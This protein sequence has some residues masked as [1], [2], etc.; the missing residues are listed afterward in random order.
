MKLAYALK[1]IVRK[2]VH[3]FQAHKVEVHTSST[4]GEILKGR[5]AT[6]KIAKWVIKLS[7]YDIEYKPR[8]TIKAQAL[9]NIVAEW[10]E[11]QL[12]EE[13]K[14]LEFWYYDIT[15]DLQE[16]TRQSYGDKCSSESSIRRT[17]TLLPNTWGQL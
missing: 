15:R 5:E 12:P 6:E 3:Y 11:A 14:K 9:N 2:V 7:M 8:T 13:V 17:S 1:V 16:R 4:L 10:T